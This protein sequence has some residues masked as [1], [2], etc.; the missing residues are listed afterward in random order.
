M[1][2]RASKWIGAHVLWNLG[3]VKDLAPRKK[4]QTKDLSTPLGDS[5]YHKAKSWDNS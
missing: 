5:L 3:E 4:M 2:E 1:G